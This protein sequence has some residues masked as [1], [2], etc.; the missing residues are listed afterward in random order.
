MDISTQQISAVVAAV[1]R[2]FPDKSEYEQTLEI[3]W[4]LTQVRLD[5][6]EFINWRSMNLGILLL[7]ALSEAQNWRC[8][9]CGVRVSDAGSDRLTIEH[10]IPKSKG[11]NDHPDNLVMAC[12]ACNQARSNQD[13]AKFL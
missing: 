10:I 13:I 9:Y 1:R 3:A 4:S 12:Y 6:K 8:C 11:G 7:N 2:V 5:K